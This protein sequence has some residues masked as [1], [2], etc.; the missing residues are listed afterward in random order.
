VQ[1]VALSGSSIQISW[2]AP[3]SGG[4][5][6]WYS[7]WRN[8]T[9]LGEVLPPSI[10]TYTDGGLSA[11]TEYYYVVFAHNDS[12]SASSQPV[13]ATT[14]RSPAPGVPTNV[15]AVAQS[16]SSILI[17]W[18]APSSGEV[19]SYIIWRAGSVDGNYT[20]IGGSYELSYTDTKLSAGTTYY[21]K[22]SANGGYG[23]SDRSPSVSATTNQGI[24]GTPTNVTATALSSTSI[25]ITWDEVTGA[26]SYNVY[27]PEEAGSSSNF[28]LLDTVPTNSY[29]DNGVKAGQTWYYKVSAVNSADEEGAQ[30]VSVS[31]KTPSSG[32][33]GGTTEYRIAQAIFSTCS[34]SGASL[35]FNWTLTT[36]GKTPTGFTYTSPS[37]IVVSVQTS[38][39]SYRDLET[40][41]GSARK[42][43]LNNFESWATGTNADG[44]V[45][46]R[47]TCVGD[48]NNTISYSAY[49]ISANAFTFS[50]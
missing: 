8:G 39:G 15:T 26:T 48:N 28:V 5:P 18:N 42:Y 22:V 41:P 13:S 50:Y 29:T 17:S 37:S 23:E 45:Y 9:D 47:V 31:A 6:T 1:A 49:S 40:L 12:G 2:D 14:L 25:K 36:T 46:F 38:E 4:T 33:S 11:E 30:S 20:Q 21:Y 35:V 32:G 7:L 43:T 27:S 16:S 44:R 34:K 24:P 3:S 10:T 19:M